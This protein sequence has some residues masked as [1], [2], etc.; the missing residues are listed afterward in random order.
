MQGDGIVTVSID[1][2]I[3]GLDAEGGFPIGNGNVGI[4]IIKFSAHE[5]GIEIGGRSSPSGNTISGNMNGQINIIGGKGT[6]IGGNRIG[7]TSDGLQ[8]VE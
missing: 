5:A 2:N 4:E 1:F 7:T 8:Q 3:I 6:H